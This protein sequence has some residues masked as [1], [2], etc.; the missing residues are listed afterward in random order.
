MDNFCTCHKKSPISQ[1]SAS[2][3][4]NKLHHI[5]QYRFNPAIKESPIRID[6]KLLLF[7]IKQCSP[8]IGNHFD[9]RGMAQEIV[10]VMTDDFKLR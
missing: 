5:L 10:A 9:F 3:G 1:L 4:L 8:C 6:L 2:I 7:K